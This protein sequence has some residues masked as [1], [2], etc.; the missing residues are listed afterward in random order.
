M[1]TVWFCT[2]DALQVRQFSL[3][4]FTHTSSARKTNLRHKKRWVKWSGR[5]AGSS[6]SEVTTECVRTGTGLV[7]VRRDRGREFQ[8]FR[9]ATLKLRAPD[10]VQT[11]G[12]QRTLV[13]ESLREH[14]E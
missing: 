12:V 14:V 2:S 6:G 4:T 5:T 13:L 7:Q 11:N 1:R 8:I 9:A 3:F 10:D